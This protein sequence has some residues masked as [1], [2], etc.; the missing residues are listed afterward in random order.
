MVPD[1]SC[2]ADDI[3]VAACARPTPEQ[4]VVPIRGSTRGAKTSPCQTLARGEGTPYNLGQDLRPSPAIPFGDHYKLRSTCRGTR[5]PELVRVPIQLWQALRR[6]SCLGV[7][8]AV[9]TTS[10]RAAQAR[11]PRPPMTRGE[12]ATPSAVRSALDRP[13]RL[14]ILGRRPRFPRGCFTADGRALPRHDA[15]PSCRRAASR[16]PR[17]LAMWSSARR[18][19]ITSTS[20]AFSSTPSPR[21]G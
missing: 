19:P 2:T 15:R 17:N 5:P 4:R 14:S 6:A 1:L 7:D 12:R 21:D 16:P 18:S 13:L 20:A 9:D 10:P 3:D 8:K 11:R